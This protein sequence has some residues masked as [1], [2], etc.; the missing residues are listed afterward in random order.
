MKTTN[1]RKSPA[2]DGRD[3][4]ACQPVFDTLLREAGVTKQ[5]EEAARMAAIVVELYRQGVRDPEY[6]RLMVEG[7]RGLFKQAKTGDLAA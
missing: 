2:F 5:S 1:V 6:L 3:L 4:A 7:A